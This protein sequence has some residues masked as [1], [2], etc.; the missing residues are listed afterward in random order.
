MCVITVA[1]F[2]QKL[3]EGAY[4]LNFGYF[5]DTK[6]FTLKT[7]QNI[8]Y[9][10]SIGIL[11]DNTEAL[12]LTEPNTGNWF[13]GI[14]GMQMNRIPSFV[15]IAVTGDQLERILTS[16]TIVGAMGFNARFTPAKEVVMFQGIAMLND[17]KWKVFDSFI[18]RLNNAASGTIPRIKLEDFED[19]AEVLK[20]NNEN[21]FEKNNQKDAKIYNDRGLS[22]YYQN[23]YDQAIAN[24]TE[25]IRLN[26]Q[27]VEAY[28]NRGLAYI[29]KGNYDRA[30]P[31]LDQA[32]KL[33]PNF[34]PAHFNRG[35]AYSGKGEYDTAMASY[36]EAIRVNPGYAD[37][38]N[39]RGVIYY[40]KKEYD[41]AIADYNEA[42]R[43]DSHHVNAHT[44]RGNSYQMK[45][46]YDR[47]IADYNE[48]IRL[49]PNHA[50][51]YNNRG[52]AYKNQGNILQAIA[53]YE[54]ALQ[55]EPNH[56]LAKNNL[57]RIRQTMPEMLSFET[58]LFL[59]DAGEGW[60]RDAGGHWWVAYPVNEGYFINDMKWSFQQ[61]EKDF[62]EY[63]IET[64]IYNKLVGG[65]QEETA[66]GI[67]FHF[68]DASD[69]IVM[70]KLKS[71]VNL[72]HT[73]YDKGVDELL[74]TLNRVE[75]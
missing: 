72:Y 55:I 40:N 8:L 57:E 52:V 67:T 4:R 1:S 38:Y 29:D 9:H 54:A 21:D 12:I 19:D 49:N 39:N 74:I 18:E 56:T 47:A 69:L 26:P 70:K 13:V 42:I 63:N 53:D 22:Y 30:I 17:D 60:F 31:D 44:N 48:A 27:F 65:I 64:R 28:N 34:M 25:A 66:D 58:A 46:D 75:K 11:K 32:L 59:D 35:K 68:E 14:G 36:N 41:R 24:Y 5:V 16:L 62:Y 7:T 37:S 71:P 73:N 51:A 23:D 61:R 6:A 50:M 15:G 33:N 20:Q 45:G 2:S 3:E 43:L 10:L